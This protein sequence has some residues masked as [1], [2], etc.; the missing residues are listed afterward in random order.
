MLISVL[1]SKMS[2]FRYNCF[3]S[4]SRAGNCDVNSEV[5]AEVRKLEEAWGGD[6]HNKDLGAL[7]NTVA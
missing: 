4:L 7:D 2:I 1:D 5:I 3:I 6:H